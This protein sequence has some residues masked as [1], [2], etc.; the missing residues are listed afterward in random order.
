MEKFLKK[1]GIP[2]KK[3]YTKGISYRG[4]LFSPDAAFYAKKELF[5]GIRFFEGP[6]KKELREFSI[7]ISRR[8]GRR[9]YSCR[10][11]WT[12]TSIN[13]GSHRNPKNG[14]SSYPPSDQPILTL[15]STD[16]EHL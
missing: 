1:K 14:G 15:Q 7:I 2:Y 4:Y 3:G 12:N 16:V 9:L 13:L 5:I 10:R 11:T 6:E 8:S